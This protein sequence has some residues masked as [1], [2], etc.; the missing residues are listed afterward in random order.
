MPP[1]IDIIRPSPPGKLLELKQRT[2]MLMGRKEIDNLVSGVSE[3]DLMMLNQGLKLSP[4]FSMVLLP[5]VPAFKL[6]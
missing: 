4:P 1:N 5:P 2:V 3:L 6:S